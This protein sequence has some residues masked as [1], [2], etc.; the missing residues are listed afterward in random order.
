MLQLACSLSPRQVLMLL[1]ANP[2]RPKSAANN[3]S[4]LRNAM[5]WR[6]GSVRFT[7]DRNSDKVGCPMS[8][9]PSDPACV[10]I[11]QLHWSPTD[12]QPLATAIAMHATLRLRNEECRTFIR[13]RLGEA[14]SPHDIRHPLMNHCCKYA[15]K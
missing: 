1:A 6:S 5:H 3:F 13:R 14:F 2:G 11:Y 8:A 15:H 4:A 12:M 9:V 7:D 10:E